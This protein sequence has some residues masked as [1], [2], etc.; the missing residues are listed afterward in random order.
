MKNDL[1]KRPIKKNWKLEKLN[2]ELKRFITKAGL[3]KPSSYEEI[4]FEADGIE[5][6]DTN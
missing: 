3:P 2:N 6:Y 5:V 4:E 1:T